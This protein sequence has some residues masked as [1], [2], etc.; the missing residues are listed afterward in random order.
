MNPLGLATRLISAAAA[1]ATTLALFGTV[2]SFAGPE[3]GVLIAKTQ[4]AEQLAA[5][6]AALTVASND[7]TKVGR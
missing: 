7:T 2:A 6:P 3:R 1:V 4:R 5:T